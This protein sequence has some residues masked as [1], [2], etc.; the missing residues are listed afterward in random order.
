MVPLK[1]SAGTLNGLDLTAPIPVWNDL[2]N[3]D[4]A[5]ARWFPLPQFENVELPKADSQF[6]EANK[7]REAS[8][9]SFGQRIHLLSF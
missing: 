4:D 2:I 8:Q 1:T 7:E 5:S 9:E 6:E 3:Q